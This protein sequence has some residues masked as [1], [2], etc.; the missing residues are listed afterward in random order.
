LKVYE[1]EKCRKELLKV[2]LSFLL[3]SDKRN[4]IEVISVIMTLAQ[5]LDESLSIKQFCS[6]SLLIIRSKIK[7]NF[8]T[9]NFEENIEFEENLK[10]MNEKEENENNER[11]IEENENN[12]RVIEE[13]ENNERVIEENKN[14]NRVIENENN[15]RV[16][17]ENENNKRVIEENI[18]QNLDSNKKFR[19]NDCEVD[20]ILK[21]FD[22]T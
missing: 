20:D 13:I 12:R 6:E 8:L 21:D 22:S 3:N 11:V 10:E 9:I 14:N 15:G 1:S 2:L 4:P 19:S 5:R 16:I 7:S 18:E 17:E